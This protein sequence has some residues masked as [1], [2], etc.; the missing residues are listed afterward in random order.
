MPNISII[1]LPE[2]SCICLHKKKIR[3]FS[4]LSKALHQEEYLRC[5][6]HLLAG[7]QPDMKQCNTLYVGWGFIVLI[8]IFVAKKYI[9]SAKHIRNRLS[10]PQAYRIV[11]GQGTK[12]TSI[13][14]WKSYPS[15]NTNTNFGRNESRNM[16]RTTAIFMKHK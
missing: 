9:I 7:N 1:M 3:M 16:I 11:F 5:Y 12:K 4:P 10:V 13:E 2:G 14:M 15:E 8:Y 6:V